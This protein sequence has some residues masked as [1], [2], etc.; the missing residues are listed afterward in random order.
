LGVTIGY[1]SDEFNAYVLSFTK[2][3]AGRNTQYTSTLKKFGLDFERAPNL[4][5][6]AYLLWV[7]K[8]Y[9]GKLSITKRGTMNLSLFPVVGLGITK[10]EHKP[11][12][13]ATAG[14][15]TKFYFT[16]SVSLHAELRFQFQQAPNPFL[17]D[18]GGAA[19]DEPSVNECAPKPSPS[20]FA[21]K[22]YLSNIMDVG[23]SFLF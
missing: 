20:D 19:C 2:W 9:Y 18:K 13:G 17:G 7:M 22:W 4:E 11:N 15:G 1:H 5:Y 8:N 14:L 16:K 3:F 10:Y 23:V 21:E 6:S 12:F